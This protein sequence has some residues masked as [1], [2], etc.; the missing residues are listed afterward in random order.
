MSSV[1]IVAEELKTEISDSI[2]Q[3]ELVRISLGKRNL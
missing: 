2:L 1:P 3:D